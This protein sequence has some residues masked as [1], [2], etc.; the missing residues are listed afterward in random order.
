[1]AGVGEVNYLSPTQ[2]REAFDSAQ[3]E[4][5]DFLVTVTY[6]SDGIPFGIPGTGFLCEMIDLHETTKT[7]DRTTLKD[8]LIAIYKEFG[9]LNIT[10]VYDLSRTFDAAKGDLS[11]LPTADLASARTEIDR[12]R[13]FKEWE[14][15]PFLKRLFTSPKI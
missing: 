15:Q 6:C 13:A 12:D 3:K 2:I 9:N 4:K 11:S 8:D 14:A 7:M 1:M 5:H 10:G